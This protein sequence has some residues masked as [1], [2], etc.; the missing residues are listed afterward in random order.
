MTKC[1]DGKVRY[2]MKRV[3]RGKPDLV[4]TGLELVEKLAVLLPPP[5][6]NL[7]RYHGVF[8]RCTARTSFVMSSAD[9]LARPRVR[10]LAPSRFQSTRRRALWN[11][12]GQAVVV[13]S[14]L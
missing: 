6:V 13:A 8:V 9:P 5:R 10:G 2:T 3:I 1:D 14:G 12:R 4:M 7:V 11:T